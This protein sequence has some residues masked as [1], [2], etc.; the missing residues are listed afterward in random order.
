MA[1]HASNRKARHNS[2]KPTHGFTLVELLVVISIIGVLV[3]LLL[4][5]I[6]AARESAR[7][8][9]CTNKLKQV[10]LAMQ[11]YHSA[12]RHFPSGSNLHDEERKTGISWNVVVLPY[13]E[14]GT[15]YDQIQPL[16]NGGAA[17]FAPEFDLI[18]AYVCPS[19]LAQPNDP[20]VWKNSNYSA[21][22]GSF[23][24]SESM[25]LS[26]NC[27]DVF[28]DGI[29]Y[30]GSRTPISRVIDGTSNTLAVGE[31]TYI[32]RNWMYGSEYRGDPFPEASNSNLC[33]GSSH[34]ILAPINPNPKIFGY[35]KLDPD[36]LPSD[37]EVKLNDL[38]FGS[39][40]PGGAN[41]MYADGSIHFLDDGIDFTLYQNMASKD[42]GE[43]TGPP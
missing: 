21:V 40:H 29:F 7:R 18:E 38:Y 33:S 32:I 19:A 30:A 25:G 22:S 13:L 31:R 35:Y 37:P 2:V 11:N 3:G 6:Q 43:V 16:P 1:R 42:G 5:A 36:K 27:G 17:N 26:G 34:N 8:L 10:G 20:E 12:Q 39:D 15:L 9:Q 28:T 41:F 14:L 23:R 4:P 24:N